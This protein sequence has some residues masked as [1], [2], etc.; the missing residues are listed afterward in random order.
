[1]LPDHDRRVWVKVKF[2]V[3]NRVRIL[4]GGLVKGSDIDRKAVAMTRANNANLP[5]GDELRVK[6]ADFRDL[7]VIKRG[8]IVCN[9][10]YGIRMTPEGDMGAF[11]KDFG[12]FLKQK[13]AGCRAFVYFGEPELAKQVGLKAKQRL[14]LRNGGLD[15]RL[16]SY[17]LF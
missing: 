6:T 1:M 4:A 15:G 7:P 14:P 5:G 16:V 17:D 9:P 3:D 2:E 12:D 13:C 8:L 10:P 11:M